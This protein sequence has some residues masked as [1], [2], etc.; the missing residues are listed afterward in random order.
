MSTQISSIYNN[1]RPI[2]IGPSPDPFVL[3]EISE[4]P[5]NHLIQLNS[6]S[7]NAFVQYPI[8]NLTFSIDDIDGIIQLV[9]GLAVLTCRDDKIIYIFSPKLHET[10]FIA[11]LLYAFIENLVYGNLIEGVELIKSCK[12]PVKYLKIMRDLLKPIHI[13]NSKSFFSNYYDTKV[14]SS[15]FQREFM[16]SEALFQAYKSPHDDKYIKKIS[17]I[18]TPKIAH[19]NGRKVSLPENWNIIEENKDFKTKLYIM[20]DVLDDKVKSNLSEFNKLK[21]EIGIQPIF[22]YTSTEGDWGSKEKD[23]EYAGLNFLGKAWK[24]TLLKSLF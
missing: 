16:N 3:R 13:I 1:Y 17:G 8:T 10:I 23:G 19:E 24:I 12:M 11:S 6:T 9:R 2:Y 21:E 5:I 14:Y 22:N 15:H 7:F 18:K 20:V 4:S